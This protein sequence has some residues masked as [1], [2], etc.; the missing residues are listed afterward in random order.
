[1]ITWGVM[2][3]TFRKVLAVS[4]AFSLSRSFHLSD[5]KGKLARRHSATRASLKSRTFNVIAIS[6][7]SL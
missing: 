2:D 5:N 1:M 6:P 4:A 3:G 7:T